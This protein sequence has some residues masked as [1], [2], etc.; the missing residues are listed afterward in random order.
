[1][2][3]MEVNGRVEMLPQATRLGGGAFWVPAVPVAR[4]LGAKVAFNPTTRATKF[5]LEFLRYLP[6]PS[7]SSCA[8]LSHLPD[9]SAPPELAEFDPQVRAE[10]KQRGRVP[11]ACFGNFSGGG[12]GDIALLVWDP[13]PPRLGLSAIVMVGDAFGWQSYETMGVSLPDLTPPQR[14]SFSLRT[15]PAGEVALPDGR[16]VTLPHD[17][18]ELLDSGTVRDVC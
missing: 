15:H 7:H 12:H 10:A 1:M 4:A 3:A 2:A 8:V 16:R 5:E 9:G 13:G 11:F 6:K 18:I 17:G 14:I